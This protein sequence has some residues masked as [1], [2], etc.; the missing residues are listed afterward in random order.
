VSRPARL[1]IVTLAMVA[2][3]CGGDRGDAGTRNVDATV[4]RVHGVASPACSDV[5]YG[6]PGRPRLLIVS[7]FALQGGFRSETLQMTQ[8]IQLVLERHGYRAG[9]YTVGYQA[10]DDATAKAG[11]S[12]PQ[13]CR[14][15]G[16]AFARTRQVIGVIGTFFSSCTAELLPVVNRLSGGALV[17]VSA[18]SSYIGLT[19]GGPGTQAG[20]PGRFYPSGRRN[21]VRLVAS[22]DRQ[23]AANAMLA[24]QRGVKRAFVVHDGE[25]FGQGVAAAFREAAR[26]K[27]IKI[28]GYRAWDPKARSYARLAREAR[29]AR[30][31]GVF[32]G[33]ILFNNGAQLVRDLRAALGL[34]ATLMGP[35]GMGPPSALVQRAG[36]AAE[37]M[38]LTRP[39]IPREVLGADGRRFHDLVLERTGKPPCCYTMHAAQAADVLLGAIA[40]SDGTRASVRDR[41]LRT[42]VHDGILGSFGFDR[43]GDTTLT[44]IFIHRIVDG[45]LTFEAMVTPPAALTG[46]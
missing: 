4:P 28:V 11:V 2:A 40:G 35:D 13:R 41:V 29:V 34:G 31:D 8:A 26:A 16:R 44:R 21:F 12:V 30:A 15:N 18:A 24:A 19:H 37:G 27:G 22:D 32:L 1:L 36:N 14:A 5:H 20:D 43:N 17:V 45:Q 10:C 7:S 38:T 23:G 9:R 3:A 33:G 6:R 39:D 46:G 25:L 42:K